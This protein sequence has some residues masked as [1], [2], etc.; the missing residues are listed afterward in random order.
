M[1]VKP[2]VKY[3]LHIEHTIS[4]VQEDKEGLELNGTH[5][6]LVCENKII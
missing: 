6:L 1:N 4:K 2:S 3:Q 5:Q